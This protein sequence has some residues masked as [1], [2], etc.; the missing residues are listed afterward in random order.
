MIEIITDVP[1]HVAAFRATGEVTKEDYEKVVIPRVDAFVKREGKIHFLLVVDTSIG[2]F[3]FGA[4]MKDLGLGLKHFTKWHRM[5]IVSEQA[6]VIA[7]TD[8]FSYIAP[9]EAKGFKHAEME[10]AIQW[11]SS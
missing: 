5:A 3:E 6:G 9:G 2:N 8:V 10:E 4:F 11:V 7:F 1:G